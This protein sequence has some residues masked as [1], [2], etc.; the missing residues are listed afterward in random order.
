MHKTNIRVWDAGGIIAKAVLSWSNPPINL[1]TWLHNNIP[2]VT[3]C[4][5]HKP[6][7]HAND[8]ILIN[9]HTLYMMDLRD[10]KNYE[11]V[12]VLLVIKSAV[13]QKF[14]SVKEYAKRIIATHR[15]QP[16]EPLPKVCALWHHN[17]VQ[18]PLLTPHPDATPCGMVA[19]TPSVVRDVLALQQYYRCLEGAVTSIKTFFND[20]DRNHLTM[21]VCG[22]MTFDTLLALLTSTSPKYD[23]SAPFDR[24]AALLKECQRLHC[25]LVYYQICPTGEYA[26]LPAG[27]HVPAR[28]F[29]NSKWKSIMYD[30]QIKTIGDES[31]VNACN[32]NKLQLTNVVMLGRTAFWMSGV[33][34]VDFRGAPLKHIPECTFLGCVCLHTIHF[35]D[36]LKTIGASAFMNTNLNQL[37]LPSSVRHVG[38]SFCRNTPVKL[39]IMPC[40]VPAHAFENCMNLSKVYLQKEAKTIGQCAFKCTQALSHVN[41]SRVN[42]IGA[43]AFAHSGMSGTICV[44]GVVCANAFNYCRNLKIVVLGKKTSLL[45]C[46]FANCARL[47]HVLVQPDFDKL[48]HFQVP[49]LGWIWSENSAFK[50]CNYMLRWDNGIRLNITPG[51]TSPYVNIFGFY[52]WA[53]YRHDNVNKY[54]LMVQTLLS[55]AMDVAK[56][57]LP[58]AHIMSFL[59]DS[60]APLTETH[61]SI[62]IADLKTQQQTT[63]VTLENRA[64]TLLSYARSPIVRRTPNN[65]IIIT[66]RGIVAYPTLLSK[67]LSTELNIPVSVFQSSTTAE[68]TTLTVMPLKPPLYNNYYRLSAKMHL[69]FK[70]V[71]DKSSTCNGFATPLTSVMPMQ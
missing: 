8:A 16:G 53:E 23:L 20:D 60:D 19:P 14:L 66:L 69:A 49:E 46:A 15:G 68:T 21:F 52:N 61:S 71:I 26:M 17:E 41:L 18:V 24:T 65:E 12:E 11:Y 56:L 27:A 13:P 36:G 2:G 5:A 22:H 44:R 63:A 59:R 28:W 7:W 45:S 50:N 40:N 30:S 58:V 67:W 64:A 42:L 4:S 55:R 10:F 51:T 25:A 54:F 33:R 6:G 70:K 37:I 32:I 47:S 35:N 38:P 62:T 34:E 1:L 57:S 3:L 31:F 48:H 43:S 9:A 29:C 39:V